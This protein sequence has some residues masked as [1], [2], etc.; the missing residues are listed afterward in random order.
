MASATFSAGDVVLA[1]QPACVREDLA[2]V[3][4]VAPCGGYTVRW[5]AR[6]GTELL[7]A[8]LLAPLPSRASRARSVAAPQPAPAMPSPAR[9]PAKRR[10]AR[11]RGCGR[12]AREAL[13]G[14][15]RSRRSE[16]EAAG[17]CRGGQ[18]A[19]RLGSAREP[20]REGLRCCWL[21]GQSQ[22][23]VPEG[24]VPRVLQKVWRCR[25]QHAQCALGPLPRRH[26][27]CARAAVKAGGAPACNALF[28]PTLPAL[29]P[30]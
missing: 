10:A 19:V 28:S 18:A 12:R 29:A 8:A 2:T 3:V 30:P 1:R 15:T 25:L 7:A 17:G 24:A 21:Q 11:A 9:P 6:D 22:G 26:A 20:Q 23:K 13:A 4:A 14:A 16:R 5:A 27:R